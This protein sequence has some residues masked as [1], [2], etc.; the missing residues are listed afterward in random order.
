VR[1]SNR[2]KSGWPSV[3]P[4]C[5]KAVTREIAAGLYSPA[6]WHQP[7]VYF[8]HIE[9]GDSAT[10]LASGVKAVWDAIKA[11]RAAHPHPAEALGGRAPKPGKL[12]AG[13]LA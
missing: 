11:V 7:K 9:G 10:A 1:V 13:A 2:A 5:S 8:M 4:W 6:A 12:D 3:P